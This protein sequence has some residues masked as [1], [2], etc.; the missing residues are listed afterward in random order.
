MIVSDIMQTE[1]VTIQPEDTIRQAMVYLL[2]H[3]FR[4]LP[5]VNEYGKIVGI[6]SDRDLRTALPSKFAVAEDDKEI[7]DTPISSIMTPDVI[8]CHPLDFIDDVASIFYHEKISCLPVMQDGQLVGIITETD[9]LHTLV[10]LMGVHQPSSKISVEVP[11]Q[12]GVLADVAAIFK[13]LNINVS[14]VLVYLNRHNG[15]K[16]LDFRVHTIDP[17]RAIE[18]LK[19]EGYKVVWPEESGVADGQ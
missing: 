5:V 13:Q 3:R 9:I 17:R 1:I 18:Q 19:S 15:A 10:Q 4:H 12:S 16:R 11:D 2:Q 7:L 6:V 8:F 14:S